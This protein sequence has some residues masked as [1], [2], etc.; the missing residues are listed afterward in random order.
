MPATT[1][2]VVSLVVAMFGAFAA[3]L[4]GCCIYTR[5]AP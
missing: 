2:A 1:L 5:G 3:A 4:A